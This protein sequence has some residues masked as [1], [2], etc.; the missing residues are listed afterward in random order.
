[1]LKHIHPQEKSSSLHVDSIM[2]G[3][4]SEDF[5]FNSRV[6]QKS[7]VRVEEDRN[8]EE[9]SLLENWLAVKRIMIGG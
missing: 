1:M 5:V 2:F 7:A 3:E 8:E 6:P 4:T 9:V